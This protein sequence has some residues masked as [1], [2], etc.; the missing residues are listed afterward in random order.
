MEYGD[1]PESYNN[2]NM[3]RETD[4]SNLLTSDK[5]IVAFVG[6]SKN[7]TSFLVNNLAI[8]L[9]S[10]GINTAILDLTKNKNAYYIYTQNDENLR[11][12][13]YNCVENL[14]RGIA[15]GIPINKNLSVYTTSPTEEVRFDDY[16]NILETLVKNHS[17]VLLDCDFD[18][19]YNYFKESQEIYVVQTYDILTIQ[20]LTAF[21]RELKDRNI[22]EQ[23]KLKIVINKALKVRGLTE[24]M[25]VGGISSYN[26]P[27]MSYM[28]ELFDKDTV[29]YVTV[30]FEEQT[31]SKYLEGLMMCEISLNGYS[32]GL[33]E[34]LQKLGNMVYPLISSNRQQNPPK[35]YNNY[36]KRN[37]TS[38]FGRN[39]DDTLNKMRRNY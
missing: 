15:K 38:Q 30:P 24:K 35:N 21:L 10:K 11:N 22:L 17:L 23:N 7:G 29:T 28:K 37:T 5:K 8:M 19:D 26:D 14:R 27:N 36:E 34:S 31:Y 9:S 6:T 13:S 3:Q 16:G 4:L 2:T 32:K 18:T 25:I 33:L 39:I 12:I 1:L 20:P